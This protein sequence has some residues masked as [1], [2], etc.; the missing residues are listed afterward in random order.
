MFGLI[1]STLLILLISMADCLKTL[2]ENI[3]LQTLTIKISGEWLQKE[4]RRLRE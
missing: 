4:E 3:P 2:E 1:Y